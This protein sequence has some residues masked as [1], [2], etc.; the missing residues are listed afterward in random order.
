MWSSS[1]SLA[2]VE[3]VVLLSSGAVA[4]GDI[5]SAVVRYNV[6]SEA[7]VRDSG[8]SWTILRPSGFHANA[9][10]WAPQLR[11]GDIVRPSHR[12]AAPRKTA[13]KLRAVGARARRRPCGSLA[14]K[15][16][17]PRAAN[18]CPHGSFS[19]LLES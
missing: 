16:R 15:G 6:V 2:G 13:A 1:T 8:L 5:A 7:A 4:D 9:L 17:S 3:R 11:A 12:S 10:Q 14:Q 18:W 19:R